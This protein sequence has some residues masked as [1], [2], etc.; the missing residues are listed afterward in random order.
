MGVVQ[1]T[2]APDQLLDAA[3]A[4]AALVPPDSYPAYACSKRALQAMTMA[5]TDSAARLDLDWL[6]RDMSDP[7]SLRANARRYRELKGRDITWA[8]PR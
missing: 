5:A 1:T 6:S 2:A 4:R 8:L 7:K 3:V